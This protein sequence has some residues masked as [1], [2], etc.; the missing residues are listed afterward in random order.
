MD[1]QDLQ[2]LVV[3]EYNR[4][5]LRSRTRYRAL[6]KII[7]FLNS[8][9]GDDIKCLAKGKDALKDEYCHYKGEDLSGAEKSAFNELFNQFTQED[10]PTLKSKSNASEK[11]VRKDAEPSNIVCCKDSSVNSFPPIVDK[12]SEILVLGTAPGAVSLA[13]GEYYAQKGNIF[14]KV[15]SDIFNNGVSFRSYDDKV[16]CLK[17]N[18]IALWDVLK[19]CNREGSSDDMIEDEVLNDLDGFLKQYPRIRKIVFNGK[20][21][22]SYY[23]PVHPYFIAKS[24]SPANRQF[25]DEER[26]AS[27]REALT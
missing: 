26:I 1:L 10:A 7:S 19:S 25:T 4:R 2:N 12:Q 13:T 21:P 22:S 24:T 16:A 23:K 17:A 11:A 9:Y 6:D 15:I 14:W 8:K 5:D 3:Q 18:H 27:W 20:K